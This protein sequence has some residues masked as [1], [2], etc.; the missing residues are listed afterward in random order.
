MVNSQV[1]NSEVVVANFSDSLSI[2]CTFEDVDSNSVVQW[3]LNGK[4]I[5]SSLFN[6]TADRTSSVLS[7]A[8][9]T[10]GI[11]QCVVTNMDGRS[12]TGEVNVC[13]DIEG[14]STLAASSLWVRNF[15]SVL[16]T[17]PFQDSGSDVLL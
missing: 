14:E 9:E 15:I 12:A 4:K 13:G 17:H 10:A 3:L 16:S 5:N 6:T 11:Y 8:F 7:I 2:E 1:I